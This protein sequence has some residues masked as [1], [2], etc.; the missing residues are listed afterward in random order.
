MDINIINGLDT[1]EGSGGLKIDNM[2]HTYGGT[3]R[4]HGNGGD[5][6]AIEPGAISGVYDFKLDNPSFAPGATGVE[7]WSGIVKVTGARIDDKIDVYVHDKDVVDPY[8]LGY[9]SPTTLVHYVEDLPVLDGDT[10][11]FDPPDR[12]K[13]VP[14]GLYLRTVFTAGSTGNP[15]PV[16]LRFVSQYFRK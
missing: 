5:V 2:Q 7:L 8:G 15:N 14:N 1:D 16:Y 13:K 10:W 11:D 12:A 9:T 3:Y 4:V 6:M